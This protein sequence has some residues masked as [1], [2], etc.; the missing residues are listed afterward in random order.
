MEA[1]D[2]PH[3]RGRFGVGIF[4]SALRIVFPEPTH[5]CLVL[6]IED[7]AVMSKSI[8]AVMDVSRLSLATLGQDLRRPK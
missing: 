6:A 5:K 1:H 4:V 7:K 2:A 3:A 8:P